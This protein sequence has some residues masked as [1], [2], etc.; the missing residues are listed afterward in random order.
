MLKP[1]V[2]MNQMAMNESIATTCCYS[3]DLVWASNYSSKYAS[4]PA[5]VLHGGKISV[6]WDYD[7]YYPL[8]ANGASVNVS[9]GWFN[10][11]LTPTY[12]YKSMVSSSSGLP[13]QSGGEW[14][15]NDTAITRYAGTDIINKDVW[16]WVDPS[17]F[18]TAKTRGLDMKHV[19]ATSPHYKWT[20]G[21]SWLA[22]H[23]A[24]QYSS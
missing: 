7:Y 5:T 11:P 12:A 4:A 21:N 18:Y 15:S 22:D 6:Y 2:S 19:G 10:V 16:Q 8:V 24:V 13:Y 9:S 14:Y 17:S 3:Y 1:I 23:D 20:S